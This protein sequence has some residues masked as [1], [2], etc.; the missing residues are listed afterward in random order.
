MPQ[1][2]YDTDILLWSEQQAELL[3]QRSAN[4]LD[5]DNL[6][7]EIADVGLSQLHVAALV[8]EAKF[9]LLKWIVGIAVA[10]V[11]T[12]IAVLKLFPAT[13]HG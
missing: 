5:W 12:V 7:E 6:A 10:Q 13:G 11:G 2:L 1:A 4:S 3:R 9:E 8:S